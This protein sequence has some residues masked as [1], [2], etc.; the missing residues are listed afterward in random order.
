MHADRGLRFLCPGWPRLS[1]H[2]TVSDQFGHARMRIVVNASNVDHVMSGLGVYSVNLIRELNKLHDDLV[3]YTSCPQVCEVVSAQV[4]KISGKVQPS[5]GQEGHFRRIIWTQTSL[6]LRLLTDRASLFLS[7][8]P[9]GML[10][11]CVPQVIVVHD[12]L[13]LHFP[14][15]YPRQQYYF[16]YCVPILLRKSQAIVADSENTKR[17]IITCYGIEADRVRVIFAGYDKKRYRMGID[18][19]GVKQ[20][21]GLTSY[22]LYVGNL[23]P[24]K[25]LRRLFHAF[26]RIAWRL[27]HTLVIA[28]NKDPRYYPALEA[29]VQALGLQ[30]KVLF[31]DYV[32]TDEIPNLYAGAEVLVFPS[33]YEGF[34]LPP[35]EA[36]A[37]G[38]PVIVSNVSSLPEVVRDAALLVDPYDVEGMAQGML[39]VLSENGLL[40]V[41]RR[42]GLER[43]KSFSWEETA[44]SMLK[45][46]E[47]VYSRGRLN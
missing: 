42:K 33:L 38:T 28:G 30:H 16:R 6:P 14:K 22:L 8:L 10:F 2:A 13:P 12:V 34:G 17:D 43:A 9:E 29:E 41:M 15:E 25:N 18:V 11:P 1:L 20:K 31:L 19:E 47:E 35:L 3:V 44:Q 23:L 46:C 7:P 32:L 39:R 21:Y 27:P 45:V 26:A 40:E 4:R 37:C 24:H 36:M 5:R